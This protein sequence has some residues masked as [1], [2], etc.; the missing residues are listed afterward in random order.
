VPPSPRHPW[1]ILAVVLL[2]SVAAVLAQFA[3]PPLMPLVMADFGIDL[4]QA[5]SL[6]SVF[7]VTGLVLALPAGIILGRFGPVA[8]GAVALASVVLGSALGALAPDYAVLLTSRLVQGTGVGLIG[9]T[10]PAVVAATFPPERRGTPMG[11]WAMWVPLGGL[12]MYYL[13]PPLAATAGWRAAWWLA[14]GLALVAGVV[15][16]VVLATGL[17]ARRGRDAPTPRI[18]G[19]D[20]APGAAPAP[21]A[22]S[23]SPPASLGVALAN[24]DIWL[25]A[26]TFGLFATAA[27]GFNTFLPTFLV[28]E[29]GL[30]LDAASQTAALVLLGAI[31]GSLASGFVSDRI[32]SRRRVYTGAGVALALLWVV[33]Y[34]VGPALLP[35]VLL[36]IGLG[37]G[38]LPAAIFASAPEAMRDQR[39]AGAGMA[40]L[41]VGQNAGMVLGPAIFGMLVTATAWSTGGLVLGGVTVVAAL[42]GWRARVR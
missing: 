2:G 38:A 39:L 5:S 27:G 36:A 23:A 35:P 32:G 7:S 26:A 13:A 37:S 17:P 1:L 31:A 20:G 40:A 42:V 25:L 19:P 22:G 6:M 29:R 24:R 15:W 21:T 3:A 10:A 14:G 33:P 41:M 11:I 34:V 16:V 12:L 4:A 18:G 28:G 30:D 9:V 8:T